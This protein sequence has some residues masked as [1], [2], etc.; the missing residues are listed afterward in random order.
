MVKNRYFCQSLQKTD[1]SIHESPSPQPSP[2]R[3]EGVTK[4]SLPMPVFAEDRSRQSITSS[5][6]SVGDRGCP[7]GS[8]IRLSLPFVR[9]GQ[10]G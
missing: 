9:G 10:V 7:Q 5:I 4:R 2:S 6:T 8:F 1:S 3:G